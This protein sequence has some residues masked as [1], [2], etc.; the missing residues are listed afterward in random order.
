M[1]APPLAAFAALILA[2]VAVPAHAAPEGDS[3]LARYRWKARVLVVLAPDAGDA[4]L[5]RQRELLTAMKTGADERDLATVEALGNS[6]QA[7]A[8]RKHFGLG[9]GFQALLVGKD[10][11]EKLTSDDP[12]GP[13]ELFPLI[14]SMPMR[15]DEMRKR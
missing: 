9:G 2:M 5:L 3:P 1:T 4:K 13:D 14:D 15:Q 8:L 10:G 12:L 11:G 7:S 6:E